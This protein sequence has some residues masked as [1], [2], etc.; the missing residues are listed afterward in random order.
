MEL[1][2]L[3]LGKDYAQAQVHT[4]HSTSAKVAFSNNVIDKKKGVITIC[5]I[6]SF[7]STKGK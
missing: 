1:S 7:I 5:Q 2:N 4:I 3:I 6:A